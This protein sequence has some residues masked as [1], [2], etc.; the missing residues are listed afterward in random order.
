MERIDQLD[1]KLR[2]L[3]RKQDFGE[4]PAYVTGCVR[5]SEK[6]MMGEFNAMKGDVYSKLT[7]LSDDVKLLGRAIDTIRNESFANVKK[8]DA[9]VANLDEYTL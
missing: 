8:A 6:K 5:E 3:E 7:K 2:E 4:Y 9:A 1:K